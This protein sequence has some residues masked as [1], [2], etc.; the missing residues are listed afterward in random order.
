MDYK[1]GY[2]F[3]NNKPFLKP[4]FLSIS[5]LL[6]VLLAWGLRWN[7]LTTLNID[8]D[9]DDYMRAAQEYTT[10]FRTGNWTAF[11][12]TN[13]RPEHPPLAKVVFGLS[14]LSL[15]EKPLIGDHPTTSEPNRYL[16]RDLLRNARITSAVFGTITAGLV[17]LVN[18]IG[19]VFLAVHAFTVKYVSQIML[20]ALPAL[21]SLLA[22]LFYI[23]W[24]QHKPKKETRLG[25]LI[26]SAIFLGLTASSKYLYCVA[27]IAIVIDWL[28]TAVENQETKKSISKILVWGSL[29]FLVFII[30]DPY[31][32]AD[33]INRLNET[34]FYHAA[35]S[36][37]ASEVESAGFPLWQPFIWLMTTP[38][39]WQPNS[40]LIAIDPLITLLALFGF[41]R[42]L[43]KQ[44]VYAI[45]I[46]VALIFLLIW[47]TKWPQYIVIL[48]AP[49]CLTASEGLKGLF[50]EPVVRLY[51]R[52]KNKNRS[53]KIIEPNNIKKALPWLIPGLTAFL[54]FTLLPLLFQAGVSL[55]D[56]NSVSMK[57]G[58][59]GGIFR[60]VWGG[61][62]GRIP[63]DNTEFPFRAKDVN[64]IGTSSYLPVFDYIKSS[65]ILFFD[66]FWTFLSVFLQSILGI[67]V[68]LLL[69]QRG[70]QFKRGWEALFILPWAIPE[71][72]G[73]LMWINIFAPAT[74]WLSLG[75][76]QYGSSFP[77]AG[78]NG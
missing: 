1:T 56:F 52:I 68:A 63:P 53:I 22:V 9:E 71:M 57:D 23:H 40:I 76:E 75:V 46:L 2:K 67:G 47:P 48:T 30:T 41:S 25:W 6:V 59:N 78:L 3:V 62:A 70:V 58:L 64:Y 17:A 74:G 45:W 54:V 4:F 50:I 31:L 8:Y 20:E 65:G 34:I 37:G 43:K 15:P 12:E 24:K 19:G 11:L 38:K 66:I 18:P 42:Q 10:I 27:G 60:E 33:P 26:P 51:D 55:T 14:L 16:P 73:A 32:W 44:P 35:Y 77:F 39:A 7:A 5:V 29:A 72:I 28:I 21:T 13:Y 49:L 36:S 61:L 69:W